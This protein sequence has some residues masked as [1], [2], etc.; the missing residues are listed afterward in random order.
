MTDAS[1][2]GSIKKEHILPVGTSSRRGTEI[3]LPAAPRPRPIRLFLVFGLTRGD[4]NRRSHHGQSYHIRPYIVKRHSDD[5]ATLQLL[6]QCRPRFLA[7]AFLQGPGTR[8]AHGR[9]GVA[10]S[11]RRARAAL[12]IRPIAQ[13]IG[14]LAKQTSPLGPQD[15]TAAEP[16][17]KG[18]IVHA[19]QFG[20]IDRIRIG[21]RLEGRLGGRRRP[22]IERANVLADVA[23]ED[24]RA[25]RRCAARAESARGVR[26]SNRR[27][28]SAHRGDRARRSRPSG[29]RR[30]R[31][32]RCRSGRSSVGSS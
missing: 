21:P 5:S 25:N 31:P 23:A 26:S 20:Q 19:K 7:I 24:P 18:R 1:C 30:C 13:G 14:G 11:F 22:A 10:K 6:S 16:L 9:I 28:T 2:L 32:D 17:A 29:R 12:A 8:L 15:G 27:C 4:R 3:I